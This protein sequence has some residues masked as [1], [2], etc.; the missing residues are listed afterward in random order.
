MS[1]FLIKPEGFTPMPI[2][3]A[4]PAIGYDGGLAFRYK[5]ARLFGVDAGI[6]FAW[7]N[8]CDFT[9]SIIFGGN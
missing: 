9:F 6:D 1:G 4:E 8:H 7:S 3:I 2:I 5:I